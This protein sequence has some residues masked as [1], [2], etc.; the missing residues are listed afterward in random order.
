MNQE[1]I[2]QLKNLRTYK[3][4]GCLDLSYKLLIDYIDELEKENNKLNHYKKLYQSVKRQKDNLKEFLIDWKDVL[5]IGKSNVEGLDL[6]EEHQLETLY[7]ILAKLEE[8]EGVV[9]V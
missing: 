6:F 9:G 4:K 3:E 1:L 2:K 5:E 8:I 7:D